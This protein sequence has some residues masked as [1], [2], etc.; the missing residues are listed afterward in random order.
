LRTRPPPIE[1]VETQATEPE[2]A[3]TSIILRGV[4]LTIRV[5]TLF[6]ELLSPCWAFNKSKKDGEG[7]G[8]SEID[9]PIEII[10]A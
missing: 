1:Q 4:E 5:K 2:A 10:A 6:G 9:I 8:K 3:E 7:W